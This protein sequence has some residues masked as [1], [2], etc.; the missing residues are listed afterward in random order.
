MYL[1]KLAPELVDACGFKN[2][3]MKQAYTAQAIKMCSLGPPITWIKS[4]CYMEW[5]KFIMTAFL[6][7][8]TNHM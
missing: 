4:S 8:E 2:S 1:T 5:Q 7:A 6:N 3:N